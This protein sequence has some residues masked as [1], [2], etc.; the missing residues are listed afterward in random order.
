M[1]RN[2]K[3]NEKAIKWILHRYIKPVKKNTHL[4]FNIYYKTFIKHLKLAIFF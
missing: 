3:N 1:H 4:W 2:Y